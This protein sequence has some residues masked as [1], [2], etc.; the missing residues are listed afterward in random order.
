MYFKYIIKFACIGLVVVSFNVSAV[1]FFTDDFESGNLDNW[2]I[3]GRQLGTHIAEVIVSDTGSLAGHLY[4]NG[5]FTEITMS[6]D[7]TFD[8]IDTFSFDL[9]VDVN[10][11]PPPAQNYYGISGVAFRF[12]GSGD[13]ILGSVWY[14]ASTTDY[15][16]NAWVSPTTSVNIISENVWHHLALDIPDLLSQISINEAD[17]LKT[18]M[19]FETYSSTWPSPTVSAELWVD[20][21]N[22]PAVPIPAAVWL[23]GSGLLSLI[24]VA[25][26]KA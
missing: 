24:G 13:A 9:Q 4:Q 26:R 18:Q 1:T 6:R 14:L 7:F 12:L 11:T 19:L 25:R 10:S 17:I 2:T 22:V 20:N 23:F 21:V 5:S 15:P 16:S 3:G 8:P